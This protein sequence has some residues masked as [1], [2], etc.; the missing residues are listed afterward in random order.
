MPQKRDK[1]FFPF[2]LTTVLI[3]LAAGYISLQ[4]FKPASIPR[5]QPSIELVSHTS[6]FVG[7]KFEHPPR[8]TV[9]DETEN[10]SPATVQ[11]VSVGIGEYEI[12]IR[13][14]PNEVMTSLAK[15]KEAE[16][17]KLV[18]PGKE[19][20][21]V[22]EEQLTG[23]HKEKF[24][25]TL[26]ELDVRL[27]NGEYNV[28]RPTTFKQRTALSGDLV[29]AYSEYF[30]NNYAVHTVLLIQDESDV[31]EISFP[32]DSSDEGQRIVSSLEIL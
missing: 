23:D 6:T 15:K 11:S 30:L 21:Q 27:K 29:T 3:L 13:R 26:R 22:Y 1:I 20:L 10:S 12:R 32:K 18:G 14:Y 16:V 7:I 19:S 4:Q 25:Q 9:F 5:Q 2:I 24:Q 28:F 8:F 31:I 17:N